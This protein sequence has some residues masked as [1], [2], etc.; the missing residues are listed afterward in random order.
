LVCARDSPRRTTRPQN[1][2]ALDVEGAMGLRNIAWRHRQVIIT[3]T[4]RRARCAAAAS[5][6]ELVQGALE[7][8][9]PPM[10]ER[11]S[12]LR[13]VGGLPAASIRRM[14]IWWVTDVHRSNLSRHSD[15]AKR[16]LR[17]TNINLR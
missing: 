11:W 5:P 4:R 6:S 2:F 17:M 9:G 15:D 3:H 14:R 13:L 7:L 16:R 12:P 10:I 1:R 8:I